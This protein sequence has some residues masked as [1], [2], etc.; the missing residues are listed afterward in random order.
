MINH[1]SLGV[2][3]YARSRAF[4]DA[5]L[6]PLGMK[7]AMEFGRGAG[8]AAAALSE[9]ADPGG[10]F[11]ITADG[12]AAEP[13]VNPRAFHIAFLAP[14]RVA[15]KAFYAAALAAGGCDNGAPGLRPDYHPNY[16]AA[17]VIDPDGY[18]IEAVCHRPQSQQ[19]LIDKDQ[20]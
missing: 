14:D 3:D 9:G 17:F 11:W 8:Y 12:D 5:V 18:R 1:L 19:P 6:T 20:K 7:V 10:M 15:V 2:A 4:Y 16:Y 13:I